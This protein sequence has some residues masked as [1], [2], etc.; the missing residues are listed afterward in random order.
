MLKAQRTTHQE[1]PREVPRPNFPYTGGRAG[2]YPVEAVMKTL[3]RGTAIAVPLKGR[4]PGVVASALRQAIAR[5]D[6]S[7][8]IRHRREGESVLC[9]VEKRA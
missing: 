7:L 1:Q 9:W 2:L 6:P 5:R 8:R 3:D 4:I